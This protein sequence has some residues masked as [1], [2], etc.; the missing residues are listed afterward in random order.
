MPPARL[1]STAEMHALRH[2]CHQLR[3]EPSA[4]LM[5]YLLSGRVRS[6]AF[7]IYLTCE[8]LDT[9]PKL[10]SVEERAVS[11]EPV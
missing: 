6:Q 9:R 1:Y 2:H 7:F 3:S 11:Q 4:C 10:A 8:D 5:K